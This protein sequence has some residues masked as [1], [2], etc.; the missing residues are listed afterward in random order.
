VSL[1][2]KAR[3]VVFFSPG[4]TMASFMEEVAHCSVEAGGEEARQA[5]SVACGRRSQ[6]RKADKDRLNAPEVGPPSYQACGVVNGTNW[7]AV[8]IASV[9]MSVP[10]WPSAAGTKLAVMEPRR[11]AMLATWRPLLTVSQPPV[12]GR[13]SNKRAFVTATSIHH[14]RMRRG[15]G[16]LRAG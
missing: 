14:F 15:R 5:V 11:I 6:D 3:D 12:S 1:I 2:E 7:L 16:Q 4:L 10:P 8:C 9:R 13:T